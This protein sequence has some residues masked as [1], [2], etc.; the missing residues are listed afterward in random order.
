MCESIIDVHRSG[1]TPNS[2][3]PLADGIGLVRFVQVPI[4]RVDFPIE[5][6]DMLAHPCE[7]RLRHLRNTGIGDDGGQ[8]RLDVRLP[9]RRDDAEFRGMPPERIDRLR[10][11]ADQHL[12]M[13]QDD[14]RRLLIHRLHR[15]RAHRRTRGRLADRFGIVAV[16]LAPFDERLHVLGWDQ[17]HPM[18]HAG[19]HPAPVVRA[20]AGFEGHLRRRQ[21][22][23]KPFDLRPP[24]LAAQRR[25]IPL[26][27]A[28]E[29]E[30]MLG[31]VDRNALDFH[32]AAFPRGWWHD[33]I[34]AHPMP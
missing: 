9:L 30:N 22:A 12:P 33:L 15:H 11:L 31:R 18:A 10:P 17:R 3:Q 20:G 27:D 5:I 29:R 28:M 2:R 34:L 4:Q 21:L 14:R 7:H 23:E 13:P 32:R 1:A 6:G 16:V 8:E 24:Q 26:I 25:S 19:E